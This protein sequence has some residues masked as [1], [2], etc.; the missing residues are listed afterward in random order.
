MN[1]IKQVQKKKKSLTKLTFESPAL[2]V[3][4]HLTDLIHMTFFLIFQSS[5]PPFFFY[6]LLFFINYI[7]KKPKKNQLMKK[8]NPKKPN[9]YIG[10]YIRMEILGRGSF[11]IVYKARHKVFY[12][13]QDQTRANLAHALSLLFL[14]K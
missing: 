9:V 8:S 7:K 1:K 3:S 2:F 4:D 14:Y 12:H 10:D 13:K 5:C 11:A 6:F